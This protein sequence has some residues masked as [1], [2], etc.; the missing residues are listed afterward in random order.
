MLVNTHVYRFRP[1]TRL[2]CIYGDL[3]RDLFDTYMVGF[4]R[5]GPR[6]RLTESA[7]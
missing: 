1:P 3:G 2:C 7:V 4:D 6:M 5:A